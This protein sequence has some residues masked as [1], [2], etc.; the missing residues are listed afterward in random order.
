MRRGYGVI[1][2]D[3]NN[4]RAHRVAYFLT[5]GELPDDLAVMHA[6]DKHRVR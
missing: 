5:H 3:G 2:H 6:C 4:K 1:W